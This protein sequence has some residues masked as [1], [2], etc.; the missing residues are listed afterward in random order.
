M[1][2]IEWKATISVNG[3]EHERFITA[4]TFKSAAETVHEW[5]LNCKGTVVELAFWQRR[6]I[7]A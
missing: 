3:R 1:E 6:T 7:A 5:A 2:L 4:D